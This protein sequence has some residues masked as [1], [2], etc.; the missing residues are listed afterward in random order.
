[1]LPVQEKA[2]K[3]FGRRLP[4]AAGAV[5]RALPQSGFVLVATADPADPA[6]V[7][8]S[9]NSLHALATD[10][11][12]DETVWRELRAVNRLLLTAAL[13]PEPLTTPMLLRP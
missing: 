3:E 1:M 7:R 9:G 10:D 6:E 8:V 2:V 5:Y 4:I 12:R 13:G 11:W